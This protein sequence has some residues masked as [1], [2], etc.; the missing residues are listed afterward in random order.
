MKQGIITG[1][2]ERRLGRCGQFGRY[3]PTNSQN[4]AFG[5]GGI[6][7]AKIG[8]LWAIWAICEL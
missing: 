6:T 4:Q 7:G 5:G 3:S 1:A 8:S 2:E